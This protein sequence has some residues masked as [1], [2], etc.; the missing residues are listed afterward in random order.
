VRK[1]LFDSGKVKSLKDFKGLKV[2]I[3]AVGNSEAFVVDEALRRSGI[4][5]NDIERVYL[6]FP[7]HI[8]AFQNKAIDASLTVEPTVTAILRAGS[9]VRLV[10]VDE[11]YPDYQTAV[12][13]YSEKFIKE[14]PDAALKFMKA[15]LRGARDYNDALADGHLTGPGADAVIAILTE[16]SHIKDP[17]TFKAITSHYFD[18]DGAV[19]LEALKRTWDF[20]KDTKQIDGSV[21]VDQVVDM[22]F[23]QK[24][25][26]ALG[27]YKKKAAGN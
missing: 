4:D 23:A 15:L 12:T 7:Q 11:V 1:D 9:A 2:A 25:A 17:T 27:P 3:S 10:G 16:Y 19:N 26:A 24:A 5:V 22:S 14:K 18:P 8:A 20:F 21:T 6:G 13:F